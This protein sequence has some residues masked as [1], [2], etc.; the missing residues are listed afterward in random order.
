[1]THALPDMLEKKILT[2]FAE[3]S[4]GALVPNKISR[5]AKTPSVNLNDS[6]FIDAKAEEE[7]FLFHFDKNLPDPVE[8][9]K[10]IQAA[11][12]R[13]PVIADTFNGLVPRPKLS[14]QIATLKGN[15]PP[16][17]NP[18]DGLTVA[19]YAALENW[20]GSKAKNYWESWGPTVSSGKEEA[21]TLSYGFHKPEDA[22]AARTNLEAR[23]QAMLQMIRAEAAKST[24]LTPEQKAELGKLQVIV[25]EHTQPE[26]GSSV[27]LVIGVPATQKAPGDE[28]LFK[29]SPLNLLTDNADAKV[30]STWKDIVRYAATYAGDKWA[31]GFPLLAGSEEI[32]GYLNNRVSQLTNDKL[33][34]AIGDV[35]KHDTFLSE[36][37]KEDKRE[38]AAA[39]FRLTGPSLEHPN[40]YR[41][42]LTL[43]ETL[44]PEQLNDSILAT[45]TTKTW[46]KI[47]SDPLTLAGDAIMQALQTRK[48][49]DAAGRD[50]KIDGAK[51]LV[52]MGD[53]KDNTIQQ[54]IAV[55]VD[56]PHAETIHQE[57][58]M[59]AMQQVLGSVPSLKGIIP[60][61]TSW[62]EEDGVCLTFDLPAGVAPAQAIKEIEALH[63]KTQVAPPAA[64]TP[65][66]P[67]TVTAT[68]GA[69][70]VP[71]ATDTVTTTG[72]KTFAKPDLK[73]PT[74]TPTAP[75][76]ETA[77]G[78]EEGKPESQMAQSA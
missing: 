60:H 31:E 30:A 50:I 52:Q 40:T 32:K 62:R 17:S 27:Q 1:M 68:N 18:A 75:L 67:T 48:V 6:R 22:I 54:S 14:D 59:E 71:P 36:K 73:S 9:I 21:I 2:L 26:W 43:P 46:E 11:L 38:H 64:S 58:V 70:D 76:A 35:L 28:I 16:A 15:F 7:V 49:Q 33:K 37:E 78:R 61:K 8:G 53:G 65:P 42:R 13:V 45:P 51:V 23:A 10:A 24:Y 25:K 72:S 5:V 39:D 57:K 66:L 20:Q 77:V 69:A 19:D 55:K 34:T 74:L 29:A 3:T 4:N 63:A 56:I 12:G 41:L 44:K 47:E